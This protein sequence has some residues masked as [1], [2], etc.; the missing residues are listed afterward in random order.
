MPFASAHSNAPFVNQA[1]EEVCE[2]AL[3]KLGGAAPGLAI[4]FFTPHY[5][6]D[7]EELAQT[8]HQ[9]LNAKAMIGVVGEW[10]LE[11]NKDIE[12]RPGLALW[13]GSWD[14]SVSIDTFKLDMEDTPDGPSL[15]GW[16]DA[17][18][19]A[20]PE[21]SLLITFADPHT[22]PAIDLYLPTLNESHPGL[23]LCGGMASNPV[24]PGQP[25]FLFQ[26]EAVSEGSVS[27]LLRG[28]PSLKTIVSQGCRP[29]G[30]T[31]VVTKAKDN[32]ILEIG[33]Q[34]PLKFLREIVEEATQE[35]KNLMDQGLLLGLA[36]NEYQE[37]FGPGDFLVRNLIGFDRRTGAMALSDRI[38]PGQTVQFQVRDPESM[39]RDLNEMLSAL[40]GTEFQPQAGLLFSCNGRSSKVFSVSDHDASAIQNSFGPIPLAGFF[41]AGEFGPVGDKCYIHSFTASAVFFG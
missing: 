3:A 32:I 33:G 24:G 38:R 25:C 2:A 11:G 9:R 28:L 14:D 26:N 8:L 30:K 37:T 40:K 5:A 13:L 22:F 23:R 39:D 41:A 16:P 10:I 15:F 35:D 17:L 34:S 29:V 20:N 21:N 1:A 31:A 19:E 12:N 7:A 18:L 4:V 27:V 36:F 6:A